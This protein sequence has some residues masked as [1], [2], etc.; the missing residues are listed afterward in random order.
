MFRQAK[1]TLNS[2]LTEQILHRS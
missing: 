1:L 2:F